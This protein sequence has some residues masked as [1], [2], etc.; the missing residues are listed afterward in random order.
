ME[1]IH[2]CR[3]ISVLHIGKNNPNKNYSLNNIII[4]H[5]TN[6]KD[7]GVII[8]ND[9]KWDLQ[10]DKVTKKAMSMTFLIKRVF[11][12]LSPEGIAKIYKSYIR[13]IIE[14]ALPVWNPQYEKNSSR[15]EKVQ[16]SATKI[17]NQMKKLS[18]QERLK[19]LNL[20][21]HEERRTR[22]DLIEIYKLAT[23]YYSCFDEN[24]FL[25]F[26][27]SSRRGHS[28]KLLKER[29]YKNPRSHFL[30]NRAFNQW[31]NLPQATIQSTSVN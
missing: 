10:T 1:I 24:E 14:Y 22:G 12:N 18:Y 30:H 9:L 27:T 20:T 5:T 4:N 11:K 26:D 8:T 2:E 29:T 7:L 3:K 28:L 19:T 13:P 16:G 6:Q 25:Q 15:L 31:N 17:S 21:T 23:N